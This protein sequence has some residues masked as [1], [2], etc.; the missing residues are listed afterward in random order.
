MAGLP[1]SLSTFEAAETICRQ[2]LVH[3]V[4]EWFM[5]CLSNIFPGQRG[6]PVRLY[7]GPGMQKTRKNHSH[8][9]ATMSSG[10]SLYMY[11]PCVNLAQT[12]RRL[13]LHSDLCC[14]RLWLGLGADP[15]L[16]SERW[17]WSMLCTGR[18]K[19]VV[20]NNTGLETTGS[21]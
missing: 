13:Y 16:G 8:Q 10:L 2:K 21:G 15:R 19:Q 18:N 4:T 11:R 5:P 20:Q 7:F 9:L 1:L 17:F 3:L 6:S 14:L 12:T